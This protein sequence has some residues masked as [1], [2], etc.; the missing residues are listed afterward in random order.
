MVIDL[1]SRLQGPLKKNLYKLA[2][3]VVE[4]GLGIRDF[5]D[6]YERTRDGYLKHPDYPSARAW[7]STGL[8]EIGGRYEVDLPQ[9]FTFPTEGP[10][11]IIS[12]HPFGILDPVILGDFISQFR[13]N[14][15]FMTNFLLGEIEE[16][17]PWII[18]VD[19]F[20]GEQSAQRNLGPMKETLRFLN[21]GGALA[22]F[23]SGEVAHYKMGRGVEESPWSSHVGA[24]VRR[25]KA[26]VLPVYFEGQNSV[27]F[28]GAGLVHPMLRTGLLFRE[29]FHR[30]R[31]TEYVKVGQPIP[32]SRLK[33]FE[34]DESLTRY[35]RLH[36]FILSQ[37]PK[38]VPKSNVKALAEAPMVAPVPT[39][40]TG[41]SALQSATLQQA[42]ELEVDRL[43]KSG[44]PIVQ[45]GNFSV[46]IASAAEIPNLLREIGRLR[47]VSFRLV[48]EGTGEEIDLDRYDDYYLHVF[49]W[50]EKERRVAGAYRLGRADMIMRR[51]GA[52]GLYT[53]TLFKFE[54]PFL[55][56][57]ENALEMGRS[58][59]APNY[60]RSV[61]ALPLLWKGVLTWVC[62]NPHYTKLYGPVSISQSYH[63]LSRKLMVEF[64][65]ENNFHPDLATWV[66][67]R[68]PFRYG[69]NRKL[70]REFI[71]ADLDNVDDFSALISSLE[72]DGKGIPILLK[73]YLRLNG[74]LLS[75]N[76]DK[77]FASCLDGL[78]LVDVTETD[79]KLLTK[80]MGEEACVK[81]LTHHG[82]GPK[83]EVAASA[84]AEG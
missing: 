27:L 19:P 13:P 41:A 84:P 58:F 34:D 38:A 49:L 81:Y 43:R 35:L 5:N 22:I 7:F 64:L 80:Y 53:S 83:A 1:S 33:K 21:Q 50:D 26:T 3:P 69:K 39:P 78:I 54:K 75:F 72:E 24:L 37:R 42:Y 2:A 71:S 20:N 10:L 45:Q 12:N 66:K 77:D 60:Q 74:T 36:T 29:L 76:V 63:G 82:I 51:Y 56:H 40:V 14:V 46:F 4:R 48:G 70:L 55:A 6:L 30:T 67:P 65:Q 17:K 79:P 47:E 9:N 57:L 15:R 62:Q 11:I 73:H 25:T 68:K 44:G 8:K 18:P 16:M 32:F 61:S 31:E 28:Q 59:V 52:K 23:P